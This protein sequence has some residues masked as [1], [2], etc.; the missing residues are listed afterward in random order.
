MKRKFKFGGRT[1]DDEKSKTMN[2]KVKIV[3]Y[4]TDKTEDVFDGD[5]IRRNKEC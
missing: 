5:T 3:F 2:K 1:P 4:D